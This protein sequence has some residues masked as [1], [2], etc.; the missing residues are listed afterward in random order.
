MVIF[1]DV[2]TEEGDRETQFMNGGPRDKGFFSSVLV[3]RVAIEGG[4]RQW[5]AFRNTARASAPL[6]TT[7][8]LGG[9]FGGLS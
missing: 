1:G 4:T 2:F 6:I 8:H 5:G 7:A 3:S 9:N